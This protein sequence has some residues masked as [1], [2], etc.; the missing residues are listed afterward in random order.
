MRGQHEDRGRVVLAFEIGVIMLLVVMVIISLWYRNNHMNQSQTP[1]EQPAPEVQFPTSPV[2]EQILKVCPSMKAVTVFG[3]TGESIDNGDYV[4]AMLI[5]R[6]SNP[7]TSSELECIASAVGYQKGQE[8]NLQKQLLRS[9]QGM[10]TGGEWY[11]IALPNQTIARCSF[12]D[13]SDGD[14]FNCFISDHR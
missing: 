10:E 11:P 5:Y 9:A 7:L 1:Q 14:M 6:E 8:S 13:G 4:D 3:P 12:V 2:Q